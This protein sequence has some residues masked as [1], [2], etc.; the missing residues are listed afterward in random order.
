[1]KVQTQQV[2]ALW[3]Q[4]QK[5]RFRK[6]TLLCKDRIEDVHFSSLTKDLLDAHALGTMPGA[7][8]TQRIKSS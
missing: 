2:E 3:G 6:G 5:S 7:D 8:V 4:V 1:M